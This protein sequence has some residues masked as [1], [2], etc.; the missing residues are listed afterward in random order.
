MWHAIHSTVGGMDEAMSQTQRRHI[1]LAVLLILN[2]WSQVAWTQRLDAQNVKR[3]FP[4]NEYEVSLLLRPTL[5][6]VEPN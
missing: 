6:S 2:L 4:S 3:L 5:P 1:N